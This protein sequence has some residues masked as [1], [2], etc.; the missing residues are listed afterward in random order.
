MTGTWPL[1]YQFSSQRYHLLFGFLR[2]L[3]I[4]F[5]GNGIHCNYSVPPH[6]M[7]AS[8]KIIR[9]FMEIPTF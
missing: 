2:L 4:I 5:S 8:L 1:S 6:N 3:L 9:K 7:V